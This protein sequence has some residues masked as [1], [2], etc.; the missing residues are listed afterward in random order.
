MPTRAVSPSSSALTAWVVEWATLEIGPPPI[1][2]TSSATRSTAAATPAAT[3]S[4]S[5]WVVGTTARATIASVATSQATAFVNV[6][7]TSTPILTAIGVSPGRQ[8][9]RAWRL[10]RRDGER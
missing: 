7:P 9:A 6:P 4:G 1:A 10:A 2:A 8:S 3:P 5:A